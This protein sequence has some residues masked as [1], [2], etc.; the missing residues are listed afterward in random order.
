MLDLNFKNP[1]SIH[2]LLR[3]FLTAKGAKKKKPKIN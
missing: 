3:Y 2:S 1:K